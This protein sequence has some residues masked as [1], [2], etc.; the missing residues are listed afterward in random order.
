MDLMSW[1]TLFQTEAAMTT[2][3]R[4]PIEEPAQDTTLTRSYLDS[5][6]GI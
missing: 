5:F 2:K 6:H 3:A 1:G 4:S